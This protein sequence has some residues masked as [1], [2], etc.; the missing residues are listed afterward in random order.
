MDKIIK[1]FVVPVLIAV[2]IVSLIFEKILIALAIL[3]VGVICILWYT[4]Y[5]KEEEEEWENLLESM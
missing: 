2:A 3:M 4:L 5:G 1:F